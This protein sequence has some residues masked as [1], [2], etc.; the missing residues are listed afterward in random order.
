MLSAKVPTRLPPKRI[1]RI[2][3]K[4]KTST[5]PTISPNPPRAR[6]QS[7]V[8]T[9]ARKSH[10]PRSKL[11]MRSTVSSTTSQTVCTTQVTTLTTTQNSPQ[12]H[13]LQQAHHQS[14]SC[15]MHCSTCCCTVPSTHEPT[16]WHSV[17]A[18][19]PPDALTCPSIVRENGCVYLR[20]LDITSVECSTHAK[21]TVS[22]R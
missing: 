22:F 12:S 4:T 11:R 2:C 6:L 16:S 17:C 3:T 19:S 13:L 1:G 7:P 21:A 20:S 15:S 8:K 10:V 9:P 18:I 5:P 14:Q